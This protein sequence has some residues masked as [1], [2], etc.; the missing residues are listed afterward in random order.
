MMQS[1]AQL[2]TFSRR[3]WRGCAKFGGDELSTLLQGS[4]SWRPGPEADEALQVSEGPVRVKL[5]A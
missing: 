5:A 2:N 3:R 4:G 1:I